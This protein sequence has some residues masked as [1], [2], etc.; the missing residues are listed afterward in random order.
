MNFGNNRTV[1]SFG[2]SL[3]TSLAMER[4]FG[5]DE[6]VYDKDR[7]FD[8]KD[9]S[10]YDI[11]IVSVYTII[12][13]IVGS[14]SLTDKHRTLEGNK[15]K[16]ITNI[17]NDEIKIIEGLCSN[18]DIDVVVLCIDY[19]KLKQFAFNDLTKPTQN[20]MVTGLTSRALS[21]IKT[22]NKHIKHTFKFKGRVLLFSHIGIDL[23]NSENND[24]ELLESNT[25]AIIK[26][27]NF[28]KKYRKSTLDYSILP[29]AT[30]LIKIFGDA[31]G[32]LKSSSY[33]YKKDI[34]D[35]LIKNKVNVSFTNKD[36]NKIIDKIK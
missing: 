33:K 22:N 8:I 13:N 3:A 12:R 28:N 32:L 30:S 18:M 5:T 19:S 15:L 4:F 29:M 17:V 24:I 26:P 25:G 7:D 35:I 20:N 1:G 31:S 16:E 36:I 10:E 34:L 2:L 21:K 11:L 27:I 23:L 9:I 14:L 6:L